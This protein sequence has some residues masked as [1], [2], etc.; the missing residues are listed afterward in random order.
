MQEVNTVTKMS[1][2]TRDIHERSGSLRDPEIRSALRLKLRTIYAHEPDTAIIDELS[3]CLGEAR[4]DM[5]VINGSLSGYEIKSDRDKLVR[6]PQQLAVYDLCFDTMTVVVGSKHIASCYKVVPRYWGIWEAIRCAQGVRIESRR[7]SEVNERVAPERVVQLLWRQ[8]VIESLLALGHALP[9]N[10]S[11]R[12]LWANLV[13][14]VSRDHLLEIVRDRIRARGDWRVGPTP[15][16]CG[17]LS[18]S[19]ATSQRSQK[20]RQWLLSRRFQHR[21]D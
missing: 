3:L 8:E 11:R 10:T 13:A 4:V 18:R 14:A 19:A 21:H 1:Q 12:E 6:L 2:A 15:F 20:N 17:G 5:A 16:R 9:S 7:E